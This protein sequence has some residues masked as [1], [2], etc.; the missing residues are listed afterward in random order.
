[1]EPRSV[2]KTFLWLEDFCLH[3]SP[4]HAPLLQMLRAQ[5]IHLKPHHPAETLPFGIIL[6]D[7]R[8][9]F[10]RVE[11]FISRCQSTHPA[12]RFIVVSLDPDA[13][14]PVAAWSL[15]HQGAANVLTFTGNAEV[16][17]R[18]VEQLHRW[19]LIES[20]LVTPRVANLCVGKSLVW[21]NFLREVIEIAL[22]SQAPI[23]LTGESGTGKEL[24]ARL[25]HQLDNRQGKGQ[26]V[27][28]D[29]STLA[30]DL[31]G[32]EFFGHEKG[33]FTGAIAAREGAFAQANRGTLFLDEV[34]EL[35]LRLQAE[36]LRVVQEG[37]FKKLGCNQWQQ[38]SFRLV[39]ATHRH[40]PDEI[41]GGHFRLDFYYR[42]ASCI[43]LVPPLRARR[44]DIPLLADYF[45]R[46]L[47]KRERVD[48]VPEVMEVLAQRDY[49][50]NVREL[51]QLVG[52]IA[53]RHCGTGPVT[54]GDL[55]LADRPH[56]MHSDSG[57][58]ESDL[59]PVR[60]FFKKAL[61]EGMKLKD[62]K[63]IAADIA[64]QLALEEGN[65][66]LQLAAE[67]LGVTDRALQIR[68]AP[69]KDGSLI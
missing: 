1:M 8:R 41:A 5:N 62:I 27:L 43:G 46:Q 54:L 40:L 32:S 37:M 52:R 21:Q 24:V 69:K 2:G 11:D 18:I 10:P 23:L 4:W 38:T 49:P 26:Q 61:S 13:L 51:R 15:L 30:P 20:M 28:V 22:F 65:G 55:P 48:I 67:R 57:I 68:R 44:E 56:R 17:D 66:S 59:G 14:T 7:A 60:H 16:S 25:I 29:C 19:Q 64:I 31:S 53:L 58:E 34:G 3:A 12:T 33:A 36:L 35:P 63:E 42:M 47:L 50:G 6:L 9:V 45:F 39:S